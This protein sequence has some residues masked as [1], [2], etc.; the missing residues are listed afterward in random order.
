MLTTIALISAIAGLASTGYGIFQAQEAKADAETLRKSQ[1]AKIAAQEAENKSWY[2]RERNIPTL[3]REENKAA[4]S[5]AT[6]AAKE[7]NEQAESRMAIMGGSSEAGVAQRANNMKIIGQTARGIAAAGTAY[8]QR[9]ADQY[10][11]LMSQTT[12]QQENMY[13][14]QMKTYG[15]WAGNASQMASNGVQG[16]TDGAIEFA[17]ARDAAKAAKTTADV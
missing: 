16:F 6:E 9:L 14:Q 8:K 5:A 13:T 2:E 1:E 15:Q 3:E 12:G 10:H 17:K 7:Q 11:G 4:I